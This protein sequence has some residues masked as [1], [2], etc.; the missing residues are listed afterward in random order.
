MDASSILSRG[1]W[2]AST[3]AS[4]APAWLCNAGELSARHVLM[5]AG[6]MQNDQAASGRALAAE[7]EGASGSQLADPGTVVLGCIAFAAFAVLNSVERVPFLPVGRRGSSLVGA[8][9]MIVF[10]VV[11]SDTVL[12]GLGKNLPLLALVWGT[13]VLS[14]YLEKHGGLLHAMEAF[15]MWKSLGAWDSCA[16]LSVA[17]SLLSAFIGWDVGALVMSPLALKIAAQHSGMSAKPFLAAVATG[18]NAGSLLTPISNPG[19][20]IVT[21]ASGLPF[22][23]FVRKM[24]VPWVLAVII[25]AVVVVI[26]YGNHFFLSRAPALP[27]PPATSQ[28]TSYR[29]EDDETRTTAASSETEGAEGSVGGSGADAEAVRADSGT[30]AAGEEVP[31]WAAAARRHWR[32]LF[33]YAVWAACL[34]FWFAGVELGAV[35][36]CGGIAVIMA[37]GTDATEPVIKS[38][39]WPVIAYIAG[40]LIVIPAFNE[41][42]VM[43]ALWES[44]ANAGMISVVEPVGLAVLILVIII[45]T[46]IVTNVPAVLLL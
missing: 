8:L 7:G 42:G 9:L 13:M 20:V 10:R 44:L 3:N 46:N 5:S 39:E 2:P 32:G 34:V 6:W 22:A 19:N 38:A 27:K 24:A 21:L 31:A 15:C 45:F 4:L 35:A 16:R 11:P 40:I 29:S 37:E 30:D 41:T 1:A 26:S 17:T 25:N 33:A 23:T 14:H 18:A 43:A 28:S 12:A 36:L